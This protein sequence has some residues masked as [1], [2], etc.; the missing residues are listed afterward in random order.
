MEFL[1]LKKKEQ[2][3]KQNLKDK[4]GINYRAPLVLVYL[5]CLIEKLIMYEKINR[6][7]SLELE[8]LKLK[9]GNS[10]NMYVELQKQSMI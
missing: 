1:A 5:Y 6:G 9:E 10:V 8:N 4:E 3:L 2:D 7:M